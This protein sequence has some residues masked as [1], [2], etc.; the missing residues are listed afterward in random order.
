MFAIV[1][2]G[3]TMGTEYSKKE[4]V[5]GIISEVIYFPLSALVIAKL[6]V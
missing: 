4:A 3:Q 1:E 6:L 2:I 5:A